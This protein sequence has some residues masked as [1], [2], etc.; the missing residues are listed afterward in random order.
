MRALFLRLCRILFAVTLLLGVP[1]V[2]PAEVLSPTEYDIKAAFLYNFAKFVEWPQTVL[3]KN[4]D[5]FVIGIIGEDPFGSDLDRELDGK[6]VQDRKLVLRRISTVQEASACNVLFISASSA[7]H[8]ESI[9]DAIR[10]QPIL[11]VSDM[12]Q[13][14][15]RGGMVGFSMD[16]KRVRFSINIAA[17]NKADLKVSSQLLKLAKTL[18]SRRLSTIQYV[19][20]TSETIPFAAS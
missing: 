3:Q 20:L 13:F 7:G 15:Q 18:I 5:T 17:A 11:T 16:G 19:W 8:V 9:L 10:E 12:D 4:P 6:T 14:V 2:L 1:R